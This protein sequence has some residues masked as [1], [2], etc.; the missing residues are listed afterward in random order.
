MAPKYFTASENQAINRVVSALVEEQKR[1]PLSYDYTDEGQSNDAVEKLRSNG[2]IV[3][4]DTL[5]MRI[6]AEL[7]K[8][9]Q[10]VTAKKDLFKS[11]IIPDVADAIS[12]ILSRS[13]RA[14]VYEKCIELISDDS[15][16]TAIDPDSETP[17]EME[18][19]TALYKLLKP[20]LEHVILGKSDDDA[21][22]N[23]T[24]QEPC[25]YDAA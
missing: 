24:H 4:R 18:K 22:N 13:K 1:K 2:V 3:S 20:K 5:T 12:S 9:Y 8:D 21:V 10:Y 15:N 23:L 25:E 17:T 14:G 19:K 16:T 7:N 6:T 11:E